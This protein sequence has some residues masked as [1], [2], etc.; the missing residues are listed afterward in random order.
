MTQN[1]VLTILICLLFAVNPILAQ[2]DSIFPQDAQRLWD[3][4]RD[5]WASAELQ[6]S[7]YIPVRSQPHVAAINIRQGCLL[8]E[9]AVELDPGN[10]AA[11]HDLVVLY[12]SDA[13]N[14]PGRAMEALLKYIQLKSQDAQAV[15]T[16]IR[17]RMQNLDDRPTRE[18]YLKQTIPTLGNYPYIQSIA[19]AELGILTQEKLDQDTARAYFERAFGV[20]N[21]ND[22]A[23]A[24]ILA[25]PWPQVDETN[26]NLTPEQIQA[27]IQI[28]EQRKKLFHI[29]RWR[30]RVFNNPYDFQALINLI[31]ILEGFGYQNLAQVYYEHAHTLLALPSLPVGYAIPNRIALAKEMR[32]K[33]MVSCY[34]GKLYDECITIAQ[35]MQKRYPDDLLVTGLMAKAMLKLNPDAT[36][37]EASLLLRQ[38]ADRTMRK[39]LDPDKLDAQTFYQ[40][41]SELAWF[42]CF[43]DLDPVRALQYARTL[44]SG[45]SAVN[46][47]WLIGKDSTAVNRSNS[48]LAYANILNNQWQKAEE[49][50][51]IAD[52][53]DPVTALADAKILIQKNQ[54]AAAVQRLQKVDLNSSGIL[55]EPI[56]KILQELQSETGSADSTSGAVPPTTAPSP[57]AVD[58]LPITTELTPPPDTAVSPEPP[59]PIKATLASQFNNNDLLI[60]K[61]PKKV[62]L[63]SMWLPSDIFQYGAPINAKIYLSNVSDTHEQETTVTLASNNFIDPHLLITAQLSPATKEQDFKNKPLILAHRYL[64][65]KRILGPGQSNVITE[66]LCIGPLRKILEDNPRQTYRITFRLY[67]DPVP[68]GQGG[69]QSKIAALQPTPVTVTRKAFIPTAQR[70]KEYTR[71]IHSGTPD[72]RIKAIR[73]FAGL[74]REMRIAPQRYRTKTLNTKLIRK[75]ISKNLNHSDFRVRAWAAQTLASLS[76]LD[77]LGAKYLGNLI[78]DKNWLVRF[79]AIQTLSPAIDLTEY[80]RWSETLEKHAVLKRQI[81]LLR[82]IPWQVEK[83]PEI[84]LPQENEPDLGSTPATGGVP[85]APTIP[86]LPSDSGT[87]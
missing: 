80:F 32:F 48:I 40:L 25:L 15:E 1:I 2:E 24:R 36:V 67:L 33:Q 13:V 65:Q 16:F 78:N 3:L 41:Q 76:P 22:E 23:L 82:G 49:L 35:L 34:V 75:M 26:P 60:I 81:K 47:S 77:P 87:L 38:A 50:L 17:Y 18:Q 29:L 6:A 66:N 42:F 84:T 71:A 14:D 39:L 58:N 7:G 53:N 72:E 55:A 44:P 46:Q 86:T 9:A 4:A 74:L 61:A 43:F 85:V 51:Q 30:L 70:M 68:D 20:S 37:T 10:A 21:Y 73:L 5:L 69:F 31:N 56:E 79:M 62:I 57:L 8:L 64:I 27:Q 28:N 59:D 52:P 83:L 11:W 12:T 63:C 45:T 19:Y 54:N